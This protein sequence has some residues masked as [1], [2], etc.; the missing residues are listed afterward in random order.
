MR[1]NHF[2]KAVFRLGGAV[3]L[4]LTLVA[5]VPPASADDAFT[6]FLESTWPEAQKMGVA[7]ATFD[8]A[9]RGL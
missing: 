5:F 1:S 3:A 6:L 8:A 4:W 9:T 2:L 7:R